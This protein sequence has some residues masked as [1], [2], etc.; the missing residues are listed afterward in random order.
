MSVK[1]EKFSFY[2]VLAILAEKLKIKAAFYT[3]SVIS[4]SV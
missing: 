1:R 2:S 4:L 3:A